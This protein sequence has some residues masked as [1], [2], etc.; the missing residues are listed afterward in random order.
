[1]RKLL[2]LASIFVL[3][4]ALAALTDEWQTH[5]QSNPLPPIFA[6]GKDIGVG[7]P[8]LAPSTIIAEVQGDW[9]RLEH[10]L[11]WRVW[12]YAPTG[13]VYYTR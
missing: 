1:M 8:R 9:F 3:G 11:G 6:V 4:V 10:P 7:A 13:A 12:V 2:G 5:A